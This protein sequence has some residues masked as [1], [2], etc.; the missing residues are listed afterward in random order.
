MFFPHH[1]NSNYTL[2][3]LLKSLVIAIP[4]RPQNQT[5][6]E[7]RLKLLLNFPYLSVLEK[8]LSDRLAKKVFRA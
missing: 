7:Y 6:K 1:S 8:A 2:Y 4:T 3:S 5:L